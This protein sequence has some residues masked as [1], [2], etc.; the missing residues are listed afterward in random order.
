[1]NK[2]FFIYEIGVVITGLTDLHYLK[3]SFSCSTLQYLTELQKEDS[4]L[5]KVRFPTLS[6]EEFLL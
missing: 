5:A 3:Y 2:S 6:Q 1:V 4:T